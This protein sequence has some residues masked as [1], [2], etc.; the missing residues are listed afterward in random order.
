MSMGSPCATTQKYAVLTPTRPTPPLQRRVPTFRA[1]R[2]KPTPLRRWC[3]RRPPGQHAAHARGPQT[4]SATPPTC[5]PVKLQSRTPHGEHGSTGLAEPPGPMTGPLWEILH[6]M[7]HF[8]SPWA[9][10]DT[11]PGHHEVPTKPFLHHDFACPAID[12]RPP[13][14][15]RG[16]HPSDLV[17]RQ[18]FPARPTS[19]P[20]HHAKEQALRL[21]SRSHS[22]MAFRALPS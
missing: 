15:T 5:L 17:R 6:P 8:F 3:I 2:D 14:T 22:Q 19:T 16:A 1:L 7:E 21:P 10:T 4:W 11:Y 9:F 13:P 20:H 12:Q 18:P